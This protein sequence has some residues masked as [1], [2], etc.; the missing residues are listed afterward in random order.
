[1]LNL[2]LIYEVIL[3]A[4]VSF[5]INYQVDW[6]L[7]PAQLR[8]MH[9]PIGMLI[10]IFA[11]IIPHRLVYTCIA[12]ISAILM[13]PI[14]LLVLM[15]TGKIHEIPSFS[16]I[17][18]RSLTN[19]F[20]LAFAISI[21]RIMYSYSTK[22]TKAREMGSYRLVERLGFGG[23][24]EVWKATHRMLARPAAIKLIKSEAEGTKTKKTEKLSL[25]RFEREAQATSMLRSPHT[26]EVYDFGI[27]ADHTFYYVMEL[28][29]GI[30]L[31]KLVKKFGPQRPERI[32][33]ILKQACH[34]LYEAHQ[35]GFIH[36]DIKPANLF[37]CRYGTEIDFL[38]VLDFGLVKD[39]QNK[40]TDSLEDAQADTLSGT[41]GFIAPEMI[42]GEENVDGRSDI[43]AL[44]CVAYWLLTGDY[45]FPTKSPMEMVVRHATK[46]PEAPSDRIKLRIPVELEKIVMTCLEKEPDNRPQS[47]LELSN[48]LDQIKFD[49]VWT[50]T[51][52]QDWWSNNIPVKKTGSDPQKVVALSIEKTV[53][54]DQ[55][56]VLPKN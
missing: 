9:A 52:R 36:R 28:L 32:S 51:R 33:F 2:G 14:T 50:L 53:L 18:T 17:L 31:H 40:G 26:V 15:A 39:W 4:C 3:A 43:Y 16:F 29:D 54:I 22:I 5:L 25:H 44:G 1:M 42:N 21:N 11:V 30:D 6:T 13:D 37:L 19:L 10:I 23:M 27:T 38:K 34:S 8:L 12:S 20:A 56:K 45:V 35:N 46:T 55:T 41:P 47:A 49:N 7:E 48:Q 24:G